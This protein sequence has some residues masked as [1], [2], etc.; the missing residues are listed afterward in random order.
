[1]SPLTVK[2]H[3]IQVP[4]VTKSEAAE[5]YDDLPLGIKLTGGI[6]LR[7]NGLTG[8]GV[9]VAVIDSGVDSEHTGFKNKVVKSTWFRYGS[10]LSQDDH[11]THVAGTIHMMAPDADIYDYR[12][13]GDEGWGVD[14]AIVTSIY[15]ACFD[16]CDIINMSLGGRW[17]SS[18]IRGA[19]QYAHSKGVLVVC[20]AG[21][22][23][24]DSPLTNERSY[25]ALWD[26]A[27]CIAAV[28]KKDDL[29]V[30]WFSNSNPQVDYSGI[31]VDVKS[32]KPDGGF[33]SMS[34]TSM[35]CPH[36]CG[37]LTALLDKEDNPVK[38]DAAM[39]ALL[40]KYTIDIGVKGPDNVTGLGFLTFLTKSEF[41]ALFSPGP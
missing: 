24:D 28:S 29:P 27:M 33:Q 15:E 19:V 12:V 4:K 18:G 21:N 11:G 10:P 20:A 40:T 1:M 34:G 23:G 8:K 35:A 6:K 17:P 30:A 32:F 14:E 38:G 3:Q 39:R 5:N 25:P 26:E 22:E 13:F 9:K 36:V 16:G 2:P 41:D 31:G 7:E 37:L